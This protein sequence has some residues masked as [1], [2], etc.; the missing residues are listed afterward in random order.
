MQK[1]R[2]RA[3]EPTREPW[4]GPSVFK[5]CPLLVFLD[6][7]GVLH[8]L[9]PNALRFERARMLLSSLRALASSGSRCSIALTTSWRFYPMQM[10][11]D[12]LNLA[13]PGLGDL[14]EGR[15]GAIACGSRLDEALDYLARRPGPAPGAIAALDDQARLY[16]KTPPAWL[17]LCDGK[18]GFGPAQARQIQALASPT[19]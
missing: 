13:A 8:P 7:D 6:F 17:V 4:F 9:G 2:L 19:R 3:V 12:E 10:I 16:G 5:P 1:P 14:V 15:C 11:V 18:V